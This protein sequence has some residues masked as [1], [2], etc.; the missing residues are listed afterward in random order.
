MLYTQTG[1]LW[2]IMFVLFRPNIIIFLSCILIAIFSALAGYFLF[3]C[4]DAEQYKSLTII[5]IV[6]MV[7]ICSMVSQYISLIASL[8]VG[9]LWN[10]GLGTRW[11][12]RSPFL[13]ATNNIFALYVFAGSIILTYYASRYFLR[14]VILN[15]KAR[16][17]FC[18]FC[19]I[20]SGGA[21]FSLHYFLEGVI[22]N[23]F[24]F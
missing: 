18:L 1:I 10:L 9:S 24:D 7:S 13:I 11:P 4:R 22:F 21:L 17:S 23:V 6:L 16:K 19:S 3:L 2:F 15:N 8:F 12:L 14:K 20:I 5:L